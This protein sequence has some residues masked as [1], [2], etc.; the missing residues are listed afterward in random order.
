MKT[1]FYFKRKERQGIAIL[2]ICCFGSLLV[3]TIFGKIVAKLPINEKEHIA[4]HSLMDS[5]RNDTLRIDKNLWR[6]FDPNTVDSLSLSHFGMKP[7][8][9]RRLINYRNKGGQFRKPDD[10]AKIY[11]IDSMIVNRLLPYIDIAL[12]KKQGKTYF[13]NNQKEPPKRRF[14]KYKTIDINSATQENWQQFYGIG[15]SI[16]GRIIKFREALGGFQTIEQVGETYGL[17]DSLFNSIR[18]HLTNN[19]LAKK[20]NINKCS[21]EEL[22]KHPYINWKLA[23]LIIRYREQHG[24]YP[25]LEKLTEIKIITQNELEKLKGYLSMTE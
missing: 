7:L 12:P 8:I 23:K 11:G 3:P 9:I 24:P 20:I 22:A 6:T 10:I 21:I 15:P 16:A 19:T 25:D 4:L 17:S 14:A 13:K 18:P 1:I 5:L 2:L